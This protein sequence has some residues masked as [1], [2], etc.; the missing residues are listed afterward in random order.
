MA[1]PR[2]EALALAERAIAVI[3]QAGATDAD[4]SVT[5]ADRF[6]CEARD[7]DQ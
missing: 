5:I 3:T 1:D 2:D 6:G 7:R 4:A